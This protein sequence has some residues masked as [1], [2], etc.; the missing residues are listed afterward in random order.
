[1]NSVTPTTPSQVAK[2]ILYIVLTVAAVYEQAHGSLTLPVVLA[3][4]VAALGVIPVY[5]APGV[6]L[7]TVIA[8]AL[9][10]VQGLVIIVGNTL[11]FGD[12]SHLGAT[13]W[14]GLIISAFAAIGIAVVPNT[15]LPVDGGD[16]GV[17]AKRAAK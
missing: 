5:F 12:L 15:P 16:A 3:M 13:V 9:A 1:M 11:T 4:V 10:I 17:E 2:A 14:I 6:V 8:F 7:K